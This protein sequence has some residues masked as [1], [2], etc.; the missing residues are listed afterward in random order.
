M[1]VT[2]QQDRAA[3]QTG[4]LLVDLIATHQWEWL[5]GGEAPNFLTEH[6]RGF[7]ERVGEYLS[8]DMSEQI[9]QIVDGWSEAYEGEEHLLCAAA[10]QAIEKHF[11]GTVGE[12]VC[13]LAGTICAL[14]Y[15][16]EV[17]EFEGPELAET[18]TGLMNGAAEDNGR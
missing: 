16:Q 4:R 3:Y 12:L 14:D 1:C 13:E 7:G 6:V 9:G 2:S 11:A 5:N 17:D 8:I 10:V 15:S 18:V